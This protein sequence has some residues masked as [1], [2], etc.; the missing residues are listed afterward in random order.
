MVRGRPGG[1]SYHHHETGAFSFSALIGLGGGGDWYSRPRSNN[2]S[3]S[4][5]RFNDAEPQ[6]SSLHDLF[7][8]R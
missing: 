6:N 2:A 7:V 1:N 3:I 8:D 5:G 4:T